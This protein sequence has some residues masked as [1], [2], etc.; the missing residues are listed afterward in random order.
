MDPIHFFKEIALGFLCKNLLEDFLSLYLYAQILNYGLNEDLAEFSA[1]VK[2]SQVA[3]FSI[4]ISVG[5]RKA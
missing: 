5:V 3:S 4:L 2:G 1:L